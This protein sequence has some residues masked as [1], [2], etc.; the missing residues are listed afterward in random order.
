MHIMVE[1]EQRNRCK[2][3][4][5]WSEGELWSERE[6]IRGQRLGFRGNT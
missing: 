2:W 4:E 5:P 3:N 6:G 1:A